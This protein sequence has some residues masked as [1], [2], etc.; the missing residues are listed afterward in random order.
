MIINSDD[1]MTLKSHENTPDTTKVTHDGREISSFALTHVS[2]H[3]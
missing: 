1:I 3:Y 2:Q